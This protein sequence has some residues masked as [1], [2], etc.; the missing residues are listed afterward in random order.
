MSLW[1]PFKGRLRQLP[2][3]QK[4]QFKF[5]TNELPNKHAYVAF[6]EI[7][8]N[9]P[10]PSHPTLLSCSA[11]DSPVSWMQSCD[12]CPWLVRS[13]FLSTF[14]LRKVLQEKVYSRV[15]GSGISSFIT[16]SCSPA[17]H[18]FA[19]WAL[20]LCTCKRRAGCYREGRRQQQTWCSKHH[21]RNREHDQGCKGGAVQ[22]FNSC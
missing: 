17:L 15:H 6:P 3:A 7:F 14:S 8:L 10:L 5:W 12:T 13:S 1:I 4:S 2:M 20:F 21:L 22:G 19:R 9:L 16:S 11:K 18:H